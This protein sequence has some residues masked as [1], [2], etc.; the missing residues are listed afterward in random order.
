MTFLDFPCRGL[1]EAVLKEGTRSELERAELSVATIVVGEEITITR[2]LSLILC[3]FLRLTAPVDAAF[4]DSAAIS[5]GPTIFEIGLKIASGT[6]GGDALVVVTYVATGA[7]SATD[8]SLCTAAIG[9]GEGSTG[10]AV[11]FA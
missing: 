8:A 6:I 11:F 7:V 1:V 2:D 5:A 10:D 9:G 4:V 3:A